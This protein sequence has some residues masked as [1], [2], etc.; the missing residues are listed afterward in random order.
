[1]KNNSVQ[2]YGDYSLKEEAD[3]S[4]VEN[5]IRVDLMQGWLDKSGQITQ[6]PVPVGGYEF[7]LSDDKQL[8][9]T[10]TNKIGKEW[11]F[12]A[13]YSLTNKQPDIGKIK[14]IF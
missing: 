10:R 11:I 8:H 6:D 14:G 9:F 2:E 5:T 13:I 3:V 4:F 7:V 12:T 1:M